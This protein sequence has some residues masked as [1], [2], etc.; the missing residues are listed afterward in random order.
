MYQT[1]PV[2]FS[3][4]ISVPVH[5]YGDHR[6]AAVPRDLTRSAAPGHAVGINSDR[7]VIHCHRGPKRVYDR[8]DEVASLFFSARDCT[9]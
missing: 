8:T 7:S 6:R 5:V 2:R 4:G 1:R 9:T 3:R